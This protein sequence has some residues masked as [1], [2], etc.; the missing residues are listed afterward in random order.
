MGQD[1][2]RLSL[3]F[4]EHTAQRKTDKEG[5][6][7]THCELWLRPSVFKKRGYRLLD[8]DIYVPGT[9]YILSLNFTTNL[10][11]GIIICLLQIRKRMLKEV[12]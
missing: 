8:D 7:M 3:A 2:A 11:E 10:P 12:S 9:A 4:V 1:A 6:K 5:E